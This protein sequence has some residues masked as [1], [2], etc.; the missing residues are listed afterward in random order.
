MNPLK[1]ALKGTKGILSFL[2]YPV[3]IN[4]SQDNTNSLRT[5]A[6]ICGRTF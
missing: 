5:K 3:R 1:T 4:R 6:G 2:K